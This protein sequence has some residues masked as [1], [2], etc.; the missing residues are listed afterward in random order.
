MTLKG[1][2]EIYQISNE[3]MDVV[4][5]NDEEQL[6]KEM[7]SWKYKI[8]FSG[9]RYRFNILHACALKGWIQGVQVAMGSSQGCLFDLRENV[10]S[11]VLF[12]GRETTAIHLI[13]CC[14]HGADKHSL[15]GM[16]NA[17]V[18]AIDRG[19]DQ[20]IARICP[21]SEAVLRFAVEIA[22]HLDDR[23]SSKVVQTIVECGGVF[24]DR[25]KHLYRVRD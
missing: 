18:I 17:T 10:V 21:E 11:N 4:R 23:A 1:M 7:R 22:T 19:Y 9:E 6:R 16:V 20:F 24:N 12:S 15:R 14:N 2:N 5:A 3:L 13:E 8:P 25:M